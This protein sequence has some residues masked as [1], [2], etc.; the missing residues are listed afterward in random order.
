M[1]GTIRQGTFEDSTNQRRSVA[2][3]LLTGVVFVSAVVLARRVSGDASPIAEWAACLVG[4]LA[5]GI[6]VSCATIPGVL[7]EE[8]EFPDRILATGL[9]SIPGLLLGLSLLPAGSVAGV[10]SLLGIYLVAVVS[11]TFAGEFTLWDAN[12]TSQSIVS[13]G[14]GSDQEELEATTD[15]ET[16]DLP[17]AIPTAANDLSES[18][19]QNETIAHPSENPQTTQWMSRGVTAEGECAEGGC[20]AEFEAGQKIVAV[21]IAFTPAFDALPGF[22]CEPLDDSDVR[23][24]ISSQ[25]R[26]GIRIEVTRSGDPTTGQS[27]PLGWFAFAATEATA[28]KIAA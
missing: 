14:P 16:A 27:V 10:S 23:I 22:E 5:V 26:Y 3:G 20:R 15:F 1:P 12:A 24:K 13:Q 21:H 9:A 2:C 6:A 8:L 17:S 25:H 28:E 18:S 7:R 19:F 11:V 4:S